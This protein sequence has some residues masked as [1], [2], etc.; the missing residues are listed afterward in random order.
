MKW[1]MGGFVSVYAVWQVLAG[2]V[3]VEGTKECIMS[4]HVFSM[5]IAIVVRGLQCSICGKGIVKQFI[6]H[7]AA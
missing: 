6:T 2:M 5:E 3:R 7:K 4:K 1:N